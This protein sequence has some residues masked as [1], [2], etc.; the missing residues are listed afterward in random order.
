[1]SKLTNRQRVFVELYL[2]LWNATEAARQ[3][4]Y[5]NPNVIGPRKLVEVSTQALIKERLAPLQATADEVL[6]VLTSHLRSDISDFLDD[7]GLIDIQRA[8]AGKKLRVVKRIK[9]HTTRISKTDGEDIEYHDIDIELYDAQSAAD[10]LGKAL[11]VFASEAPQVNVTN[12]LAVIGVRAVDY[13]AG[14]TDLAPGPIGDSPASGGDESGSDG[15]PLGE[16]SP[17]RDVSP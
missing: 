10:K 5:K 8:R 6:A 16:D 11:G 7:N 2:T 12:N 17:G 9:Q 15:A 14:L 1:M 4:G 13:R 3:A